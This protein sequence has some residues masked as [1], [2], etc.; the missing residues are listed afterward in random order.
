[1]MLDNSCASIMVQ[2]MRQALSAFEPIPLSLEIRSIKTESKSEDLYQ[3]KCSVDSQETARNN[4]I[5]LDQG[6]TFLCSN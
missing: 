5:L 4:L 2:E 6:L 1:M 3:R